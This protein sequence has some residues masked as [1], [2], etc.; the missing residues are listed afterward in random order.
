MDLA[1]RR[2]SQDQWAAGMTTGVA[3]Q[4]QRES[5]KEQ[6]RDTRSNQRRRAG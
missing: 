2:S 1:F 4:D 6:Q 3:R 5:G